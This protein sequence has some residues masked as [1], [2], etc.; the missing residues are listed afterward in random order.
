MTCII[1]SLSHI[2]PI[3]SS[4][5]FLSC[6]HHCIFPLLSCS[7][8]C[9]MSALVRHR[10]SLFG[11]TS[12]TAFLSLTP[13]CTPFA[14]TVNAPCCEMMCRAECL[15]TGTDAAAIVNC[16]HILARSLDARFSTSTWSLTQWRN[17]CVVCPCYLVLRYKLSHP[18]QSWS[19]GLRLWKQGCA[20]SLKVP[21]MT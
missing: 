21:P 20:R 2:L 15:C 10:V 13:L 7:I 17:K 18:G 9:K 11:K 14:F 3:L 12:W 8:F 16:L 1:Y 5:C 4:Y 6:L 19:R